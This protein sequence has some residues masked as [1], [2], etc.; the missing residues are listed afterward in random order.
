MIKP[1]SG[2]YRFFIV[3]LLLIFRFIFAVIFRPILW[4]YMRRGKNI[5]STVPQPSSS[6]LYLL[7]EIIYSKVS[8]QQVLHSNCYIILLYWEMVETYIRNFVSINFMPNIQMFG[9]WKLTAE[10][11]IRENSRKMK[12]NNFLS[13][14]WWCMMN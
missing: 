14:Q 6:R 3:S 5:K 1:I 11:I 12:Q 10:K 8:L 13:N 9:K 2:V 4:E 7:Q